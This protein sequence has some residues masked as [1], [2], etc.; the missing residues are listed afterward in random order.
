MQVLQV[1]VAEDGPKLRDITRD[2]GGIECHLVRPD[3]AVAAGFSFTQR[4]VSLWTY[5]RK[6]N[7]QQ[8]WLIEMTV[9]SPPDA[10][11][12]ESWVVDAEPTEDQV[13]TI[14][15]HGVEAGSVL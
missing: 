7:G 6:S 2:L 14:I 5:T 12:Y 15:T 9:F 11:W 8:V 4:S 13:M 1:H 3:Q 10:Q